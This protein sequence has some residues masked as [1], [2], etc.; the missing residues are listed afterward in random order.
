MCTRVAPAYENI[1]PTS[2]RT[3]SVPYPR[4]RSDGVDPDPHL[5]RARRELAPGREVRLDLADLARRHL[6]R[7]VE[8]AVLHDPRPLEASKQ[9]LVFR[10]DGLHGGL[11]LESW[12]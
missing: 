7:E 2:K 12:A 4:P 9:H 6:D 1:H 5:E 11:L 10:N 8:R 3:A